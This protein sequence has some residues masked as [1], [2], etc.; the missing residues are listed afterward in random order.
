MENTK[1]SFGIFMLIFLFGVVIGVS[2]GY[3]VGNEK[4]EKLVNERLEKCESLGGEYHLY[5]SSFDKKYVDYCEVR[6]S[7][8]NLDSK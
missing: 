3:Q 4:K 2:A 5:Y 8:I 1:L 7:N 6:D